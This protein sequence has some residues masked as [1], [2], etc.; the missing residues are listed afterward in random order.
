MSLSMYQASVPTLQKMLGNLSKIAELHRVS[1]RWVIISDLRRSWLAAGGW[2]LASVAL[3]FHS[4][5]R[6]DGVTSVL[7]GFTA[8]EL[9]ALVHETTGATAEVRHGPFWRLNARWAAGSG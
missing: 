1:K 4:V 2:W 3:G 9:A 8:G 7:R 5:S 6:H